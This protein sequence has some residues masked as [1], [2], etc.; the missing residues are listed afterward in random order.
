M[1]VRSRF[2]PR[3]PQA[4]TGRKLSSQITKDMRGLN[5]TDPYG[6]LPQ[7]ASPYLRNARMYLSETH[8]Q[9]AISTR[10]GAG[11]YSIPVGE[12]ETG[13]YTATDN[14]DVTPVSSVRWIAMPFT[15]SGAGVLTMAQVKVGQDDGVA[16]LS[17]RIYDDDSGEPGALL[18]KSTIFNSEIPSSPD[19]AS[20]RFVEAPLLATATTYWLV[21]S[22]QRAN[23]DSYLLSTTD[24][25]SDALFSNNAGNSWTAEPFSINYKVHTSENSGVLGA[26]RYTPQSGTPT[27]MFAH[28]T[29]IYA[30]DDTDGST[31]S[32]KSGLNAGQERVRFTEFDD[33]VFAANN[34]NVLQRSTGGAFADVTQL[35][36]VPSNVV[37]H[38]NRLW[39][40]SAGDKNRLEFSE[41]AEYDNW[42]ASAF[43]YVPEP[44]SSDPITGLISFQDTLVVFT[45]NNKYVIYGD[46]LATFQVRQSIGQQGAV[47]QEAI[48]ADENYIYFVS[49]DG[50]MYRWN[51]SKDEQ[52]SRVIEADLDDVASPNN[53]RLTY[54]QDRIY[55]WFQGTG[56]T[57]F[58]SNFV[59][60]TR[61]NEWFYDTGRFINGG[62]VLSQEDDRVY[63]TSGRAGVL[64]LGGFGY[65]DLGRPVDFEYHTNYFDFGAPD[66]FKQVRRLYFHFRKVTGPGPVS[67]GVDVDFRNDP[68]YEEIN[69]QQGGYRWG[70]GL[71]D[72]GDS[73]VFWGT[74]D[75][76]TRYR[77][78]VPGQGTHYQVRVKKTCAE[79]P[80]YFIGHSQYYRR[81]RTA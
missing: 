67:V 17:V 28:K 58:D 52:L 69:L 20:T 7:F 38:K 60:E 5:S 51:G 62:I 72:W 22:V 53:A 80:V 9:V 19:Y 43:I 37:T 4:P 44:K 15:V 71:I 32:L 16:P 50:H 8:R 59:Y 21:V 30:I 73:E 41:L 63:F 70:D 12:A 36:T 14:A 39:I 42:E 47:S 2:A 27:T 29:D 24:D 64:Y 74:V 6:I 46:D 54:W 23:D 76:Y 33:A 77:M 18:A 75:Q 1:P 79:T 78:S 35:S 34:F 81:R 57:A 10:Q 66:N 3:V 40:V 68:L 31:T 56:Q 25:S 48:V 45:N 26:F 65:S 61:Y 49:S 13:A 55:Y 11:F